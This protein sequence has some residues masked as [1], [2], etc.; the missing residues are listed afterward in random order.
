M[1]RFATLFVTFALLLAMAIPTAG[2]WTTDTSR[3]FTFTMTAS[4]TNISD[5]VA[6]GSKLTLS[7]VM[8]NDAGYSSAYDLYQFQTELW[9]D[10]TK[11]DV[12]SVTYNSTYESADRSAGTDLW[13]VLFYFVSSSENGVSTSK[14]ISVGTVV[15]KSISNDATTD[16]ISLNNC[17]VSTQDG[18]DGYQ[19]TVAPTVVKSSSSGG[20]SSGGHSS[21][22]SSSSGGSSSGG[23]DSGSSDGSDSGGTG[24]IISFI[25]VPDTYWGKSAIDFVV[26][27]GL[28]LGTSANTFSPDMPMTRAM[29][30]TVLWRLAGEPQITGQTFSDVAEGTWYDS[31]V[32]WA[33]QNGIVN[34]YGNGLFG[35]DDAALREQ[36]AAIMMRYAKL[37]GI[38]TSG[39]DS[40]SRFS[41]GASV[42]P[43]AQDMMKWAVSY[44]LF[45]GDD[46]GK[47]NPG[48]TATRAQ[49]ATIFMRF[50]TA[51]EV[52]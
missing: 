40:L 49:V 52:G 13:R 24:T 7:I 36:I 11:F 17:V 20:S 51:A 2:A 3:S 33:Q 46:Q 22:G 18:M 31:A 26:A 14:N 10:T 8:S 37:I 25:D 50:I 35:P 1:K 21:S 47:L 44:G 6:K 39:T 42:S 48:S 43:Y 27:R 23:S 34:G 41:D 19:V 38:D 15:L 12:D 45:Q 16:D 4:G 30:V 28:F 5:T 32:A 29:M 9:F